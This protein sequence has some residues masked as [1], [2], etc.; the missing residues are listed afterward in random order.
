M[1]NSSENKTTSSVIAKVK[2]YKDASSKKP[3][4]KTQAKVTKTEMDYGES[5]TKDVLVI[6]QDAKANIEGNKESKD[7]PLDISEYQNGMELEPLNEL[8]QSSAL[9]QNASTPE[10]VSY[11]VTVGV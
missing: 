3:V 7:P 5:I 4:R 2:G 11:E 1:N 8:A 9:V 6:E 10:T